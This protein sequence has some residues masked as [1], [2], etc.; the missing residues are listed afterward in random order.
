MMVHESKVVC[1]ATVL[2]RG[3]QAPRPE[4][5]AWHQNELIATRAPRK[6]LPP[7]Q[8]CGR[9]NPKIRPWRGLRILIVIHSCAH[10]GLGRAQTVTMDYY[11]L[12]EDLEFPILKHRDV[13]LG[14]SR[15][16]RPDQVAGHLMHRSSTSGQGHRGVSPLVPF[17][18]HDHREGGETVGNNTHEELRL[19][20]EK[21][22]IVAQRHVPIEDPRDKE[23]AAESLGVTRNEPIRQRGQRGGSIHY[24]FPR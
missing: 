21:P 24:P 23:G 10:Q 2:G 13:P 20:R 18:I 9:R 11:L 7:P 14:P 4:N 17:L 19:V 22:P 8:V 3:F 1:N 5:P 6:N 15:Q 12:C 16:E